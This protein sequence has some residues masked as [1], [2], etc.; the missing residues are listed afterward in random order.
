MKKNPPRLGG[1]EGNVTGAAM[2]KGGILVTGGAGYIGSHTVRQLGEA[3]ENIVVLDNLST[4]HQA[5]VLHGQFVRGDVDDG[6]LLSNLLAEYAVDTV[7]H[8]AA[9][10]IA[11]DSV[12]NPLEYYRLNTCV[13]HKLLEQCQRHGVKNFIFSSSAAVYGMP[14]SGYAS[15][16]TP[17]SPIN[18]YGTS[19]L[20]AEWMLRDLSQ[21]S[22]MR[23][24]VLRY[25]N[26]AGCD[27]RCRIGQYTENSTLLIK[28]ACEAVLGKRPGVS[29]FGNDYQ[30]PD[31]TGVRDYIHV[32][33]LADAHLKAMDY[34]RHGGASTV[35]NVGYGHG[36]S[37][38]QVLAAIERVS[39][40]V[41]KVEECARR[42][43][44]PPMLV[45]VADKIRN[46]LNWQ[47]RYDD[48]DVIVRTALDWE[49]K[50]SVAVRQR[51][52]SEYSASREA[53]ILLR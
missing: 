44:D 31:G 39:G 25:F 49:E 13:T 26:V 20:M 16:E 2:S 42:L 8:F 38:R 14:E 4:G 22:G 28:A 29:V 21:I 30:T 48:L 24:V 27:P 34:L 7:F 37:V 43:G 47:P 9:S 51:R 45:A 35:L 33:D 41:L 36:Y 12:L 53:E 10:T 46:L 19:K 11:S 6:K 5:A 17:H 3:G 40:G 23:F 32:E 52:A 1:D 18:P 15:E 50:L